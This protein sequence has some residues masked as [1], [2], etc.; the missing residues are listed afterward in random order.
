MSQFQLAGEGLQAEPLICQEYTEQD[1][2]LKQHCGLLYI[3]AQ[4][5]M[6]E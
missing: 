4:E 1:L 3:H 5:S 2:L 6:K